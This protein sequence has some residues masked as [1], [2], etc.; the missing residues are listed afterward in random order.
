MG[1]QLLVISTDQ[2]V[3]PAVLCPLLCCAVLCSGDTW[4]RQDQVVPYCI[5]LLEVFRWVLLHW[6]GWAGLG[7]G[8]APLTTARELCTIWRRRIRA[9]E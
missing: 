3:P 2:S 7:W 9:L 8:L 6:L 1:R 5:A 4:L